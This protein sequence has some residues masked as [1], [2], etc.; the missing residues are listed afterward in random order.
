MVRKLLFTFVLLGA[1]LAFATPALAAGFW[2][3]DTWGGGGSGAGQLTYAMGTAFYHGTV[4]VADY[5][6]RIL[7]YT[8]DGAYL[9]SFGSAQLNAPR[10]IAIDRSR[11]RV[12]VC[13]E[14]NNRVDVF[15]SAG[16]YLTS[17]GGFG[18]A[19]GQ[20][21][22]PLAVAVDSAGSI[23]VGDSGTYRVQKFDASYG[24]V[25]TLD[26]TASG[27]AFV[28]ISGLAVDANDNLYV[29]DLEHGRIVKFDSSGNYVLQWSAGA[30]FGIAADRKGRV[31]VTDHWNGRL[32]LYDQTGATIDYTT[33]SSTDPFNYPDGVC[34]DGAGNIYVADWYG[35]HL[36]KFAY[37][38]TP[39]VVTT[40][41]DGEWH[42]QPFSV[43][44]SATDDMSGVW[45]PSF[46][47]ST[48]GGSNWT[49]GSSYYQDAPSD[50]S[51]DGI[52]KVSVAVEDFEDNWNYPYPTFRT[53][54]D[55]KAPITRLLDEMSYWNSGPVTLE[56][57]ASDV[58]SGVGGTMYSTDA[59]TT[60][61]PVSGDGQV[62]FS[63]ETPAEG[64]MVLYYSYDNCTDVPNVEDAKATAVYIDMTDPVVQALNN[65]TVVKGK[66]ASFK[67]TVTDNLSDYSDM[68]LVIQ[69]GTKVVKYVYLG[70]R[71]SPATATPTTV[72]KKYKVTLASGK[73]TW[74]VVGY[75]YAGNRA[76]SAAKKLTVKKP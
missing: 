36:E 72:V 46:Q 28:E 30:P 52:H 23:Y 58:G 19:N 5:S 38:D 70:S 11:G 59:G 69:K 2:W 67:Y 51:M 4:Y 73:Y 61:L 6:N 57:T 44:F 41:A 16:A 71:P 15:N 35:P 25:S 17:F 8:P 1:F 31:L 66:T 34:V 43:D 45:A 42:S 64:L 22:G 18:P 60:W 39:P 14:G 75:D 55:T 68:S 7:M 33:G 10:H 50:H 48:D 29:A 20:F 53:K 63:D 62:T 65:V 9:G 49:V 74:H 40:D 47:W 37:D 21:E 56:F 24:Y 54:V 26:P 76:Q 32:T 13:D 12:Y 27:S 3:Q